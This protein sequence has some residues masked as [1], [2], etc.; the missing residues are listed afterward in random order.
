MQV[1][2]HLLFHDGDSCRIEISPLICSG[3]QWTGFC[4]IETSVMKDS[5]HSSSTY[6]E[7][8]FLHVLK[9]NLLG[10]FYIW[11]SFTN[12]DSSQDSR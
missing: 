3:N 5:R 1:A 12:I 7:S 9:H 4:I 2:K 11:F 8:L 6:T 10:Y